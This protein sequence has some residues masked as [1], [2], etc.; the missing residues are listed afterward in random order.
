M[1][2]KDA[3]LAISSPD[4]ISVAIEYSL[5]RLKKSAQTEALMPCMHNSW[6]SS[7]IRIVDSIVARTL[8]MCVRNALFTMSG[9]NGNAQVF[10]VFPRVWLGDTFVWHCSIISSFPMAKRSGRFGLG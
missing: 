2:S 10:P 1:A 7:L 5:E 3:A 9:A 8:E 6:R 4:L